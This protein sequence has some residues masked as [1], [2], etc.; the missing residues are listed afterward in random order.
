MVQSNDLVLINELTI[1][2]LNVVCDPKLFNYGSMRDSLDDFSYTFKKG[3][4]YGLIGEC[5]AGG[6]ALSY[7][8]A[9]RHKPLSGEVLA[10]DKKQEFTLFKQLGWYLGDDNYKDDMK[11]KNI[12]AKSVHAQI[13]KGIKKNGGNYQEILDVFKLTDNRIK[14]K[15]SHIGNER[16]NASAAIGYAHSRQIFCFPWLSSGWLLRHKARFQIFF[17]IFKI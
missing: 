4:I 7:V 1:K 3:M 13:I 17:R 10:D 6:W 14:R 12:F 2:N 5:C 9:G 16:W 8:L 15:I 11:T